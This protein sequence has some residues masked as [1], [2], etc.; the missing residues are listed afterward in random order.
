MNIQ[1]YVSI[2]KTQSFSE[3]FRKIMLCTEEVIL[4]HHCNAKLLKAEYILTKGG[5]FSE[6]AQ[7]INLEYFFLRFGDLK[8]ELHFLKKSHL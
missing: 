7:D 3:F 6:R 4:P 8:K 1:R 2:D 5:I